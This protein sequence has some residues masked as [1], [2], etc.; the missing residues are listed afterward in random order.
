MARFLDLAQIA[1]RYLQGLEGLPD[2]ILPSDQADRHSWNVFPVRHPDCEQLQKQLARSGIE[3]SIRGD[4]ILLPIHPRLTRE[5]V[6]E[7]V[8][9]VRHAVCWQALAAS[10]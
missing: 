3:T 5:Q 1:Q 10:R 7:V 9:T 4:E 8:D 6:E 2:L